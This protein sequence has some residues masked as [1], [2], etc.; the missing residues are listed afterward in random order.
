MQA[1]IGQALA[2]LVAAINALDAKRAPVI[3][4][5]IVTFANGEWQAEGIFA[6]PAVTAASLIL[7]AFAPVTDAD[8]N[9]PDWL[10][11]CSLYAIPSAGQVIIG[12]ASTEPQNGPVK[13][14]YEVKNA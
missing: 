4:N 6:D 8:E 9:G 11:D 7:P 12:I 5:V 13:I 3:R 2:R 1:F 10:A 14:I